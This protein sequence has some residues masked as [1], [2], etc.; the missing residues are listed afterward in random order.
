MSEKK[1]LTVNCGLACLLEDRQGVLDNYDKIRINSGTMVVSSAINAKLSAKSAVINTGDMRICDVK[2]KIIQLDKGA[3]ID[4]GTDLKDLFVIARDYVVVK[5]DGIKALADAE[6]L[7]AL[8]DVY[9]PQSCQLSSLTKVS[10][11]K[12]AYP[13]NAFLIFGDHDLENIL[14]EARDDKKHIWVSGRITA[15]DKKVLEKAK[16]LGL[17]FYSAD[18]LTYEGFYQMYGDFFNCAKKTLVPDGHEITGNLNA[19]ELSLYGKKI[20]IQGKFTMEEKDMPALN[21]I[22]S[23]IVK[24]KANLPSS[25]LKVFKEKGRADSY[26][27]F[28]GRLVEINGFEQ[29][30]HNQLAASSIA[31]EKITLRVNGCLHFNDD[32]TAEDIGCIASLSYNGTVLVSDR[33]KAALTSKVKTGNGFMGDPSS[34]SEMT[35]MNFRDMFK[36]P[37]NAEDNSQNSDEGKVTLNLGTYILA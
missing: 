2:G 5:P 30:S 29:F 22:E 23:I 32:V 6:E 33:I 31:G 15:L 1:Q 8:G 20:Y 21:E 17:F 25:A 26:F 11:K 10:G 34:V 18:I 37:H 24:G 9:Y 7:V 16:S 12:R 4:G 28:E 19:S 3:V 35:G 14:Y 36:N 13:D 27:V